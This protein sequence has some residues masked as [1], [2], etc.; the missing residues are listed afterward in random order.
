MAGNTQTPAGWREVR[1]GDVARER[2]QRAN[3]ALRADVLSITNDLGFVQSRQ[4]FDRQ[5]FSQDTSNYKVV[6]RGDIA[7]NPARLNVGSIGILTNPEIGI[8]SPMYVVFESDTT[9]SLPEFLFRL[10]RLPSL[11]ATYRRFGEGTVRSSIGF[12]LLR[13]R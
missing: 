3:S 5:V 4:K 7:Y 6:R 9:Q 13:M 12:H 11:F 8:V 2:N 10:L 1:L